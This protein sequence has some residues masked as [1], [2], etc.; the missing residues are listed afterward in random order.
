MEGSNGEVIIAAEAFFVFSL[1]M[2]PQISKQESKQECLITRVC[3]G[4]CKGKRRDPR[5]IG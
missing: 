4:S 5:R 1:F 2:W 3:K